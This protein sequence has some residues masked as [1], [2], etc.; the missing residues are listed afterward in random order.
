L[1]NDELARVAAILENNHEYL[2]K[3]REQDPLDI[4][5]LNG[6]EVVTTGTFSDQDYTKAIVVRDG[7]GNIYVHYYG[8]G[9]GNWGYNAAAY[10]GPP[11]DM[12][13]WALTY[14]DGVVSDHYDAT[15]SGNVFLSGH[16]QGGNSAQFVTMRSENRSIIDLCAALDA[17]GFSTLFVNETK[18]ML[19]EEYDGQRNKIYAYNGEHDY[20]SCLGQESI[21]PESNVRF[22]LYTGKPMDFEAFHHISRNG[23]VLQSVQIL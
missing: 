21:I 12:Q 4:I 19:G 23:V 10:G 14:F 7:D 11:S 3:V 17:P 15:S 1:E 9:D 13:E 20:V 22:V 8:T 5:G 18:E 2:N 6:F 16:S